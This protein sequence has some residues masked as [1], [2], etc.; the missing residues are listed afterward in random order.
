MRPAALVVGLPPSAAIRVATLAGDA[1]L[2][3]FCGANWPRRSD[4]FR[5]GLALL[6]SGAALNSVPTLWAGA[7]P[8]SAVA[9]ATS[10]LSAAEIA[11]P[12]TGHVAL[13][14]EPGII[15]S[16]SD[17]IAVPSLHGVASPGDLVLIVGATTLVGCVLPR[18]RGRRAVRVRA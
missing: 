9:A 6:V 11:A 7:M 1:L 18:I 15:A 12:P 3:G 14:G 17:I 4:A 8:Y 13:V 5:V 16:L 10:G 2:I